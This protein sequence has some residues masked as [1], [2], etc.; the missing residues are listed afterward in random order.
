MF[1]SSWRCH[2]C[3][4]DAQY[5]EP[6]RS[7]CDNPQNIS[8]NV[9]AEDANIHNFKYIWLGDNGDRKPSGIG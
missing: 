3:R 8:R 5:G 9:H 2:I 4:V 1:V 6:S 7:E